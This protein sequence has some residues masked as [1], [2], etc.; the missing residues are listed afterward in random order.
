MRIHKPLDLLLQEKAALTEEIGT[1]EGQADA[2]DSEIQETKEKLTKARQFLRTRERQRAT[3]RGKAKIVM[4][5]EY[6]ELHTV[7][8]EWKKAIANLTENIKVAETAV[9]SARKRL[10]KSKERLAKVTEV[11][12]KLEAEIEARK[13]IPFPNDKQRSQ[14][15]DC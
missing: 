14:T 10:E 12:D 13:V 2:L 4:F 7:I 15:E 5:N 11:T 9:K 1:F 6:K 3:L 8:G